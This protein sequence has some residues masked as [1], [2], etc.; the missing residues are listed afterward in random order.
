[1]ALTRDDIDWIL[2]HKVSGRDAFEDGTNVP[3]VAV[4]NRK[5]REPYTLD[6]IRE[7]LRSQSDQT[8]EKTD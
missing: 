1:M 7:A 6:E 2:E 3:W 5:G 4:P 8:K